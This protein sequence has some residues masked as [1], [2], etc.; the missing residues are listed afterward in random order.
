MRPG[1]STPLG[2]NPSFT[3]LLK[4]RKFAS[5]GSNT[6]TAA[7][8][9]GGRAHQRG[10]AANAFNR[11]ADRAGVRLV[12]KRHRHPEQAAGPVVEHLR[13]RRDR[14]RD[15]VASAR[16]GRD[17]PERTRARRLAGKGFHLPHAKPERARIL[18]IEQRDRA[19]RLHQRGQRRFAV[20][21]RGRETFQAQRGGSFRLG[22]TVEIRRHVIGQMRRAG[23]IAGRA[24]GRRHGRAGARVVETFDDHGRFGFR[25]GQ[26]FDRDIGHRGQRAPGTGQHLA[27]V[28]AGDVLHHAPARFDSFGAA[29][30]GGHAEEV[31][32][33]R[34]RFDAARPGKIGRDRAA[35]GALAGLPA[36]QRAVI[37]RLEGELL[38]VFFQQHIDL[39][40]R[41][42]G[43]GRK[44]E[45]FR[46]VQRDAGEPREVEREV[47]L[48]RAADQ[49]L[50]ALPRKFQRLVVAE[51][52][53]HGLLDLFGV[54]RFEN[55][56]H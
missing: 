3:R 16:R 14:R 18:F 17:A 29:G 44:H 5:C 56:G 42:A 19:E 45:F 26:H 32:A 22:Q 13:R 55:I 6:S 23:D 24:H 35:D 27:H 54:A 21:H 36:Q 40:K 8:D 37:H 48:A 49:A 41:R 9:C 52:P 4:A 2:S 7:R 50:G 39:G 47:S 30:D 51:R 53:A 25:L 33:R 12:G 43:F 20:L 1:L 46:L 31:I 28:V 10:V 11:G 15:F 38:V 34:A